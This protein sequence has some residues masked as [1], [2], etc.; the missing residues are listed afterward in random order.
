MNNTDF[1]CLAIIPARG[2]SRGLPG[3]NLQTVGG[4]TL[5]YRAVRAA[6]ESGCCHRV[7]CSTDDDAISAEAVRAGG[8]VPFRRPDE[9]A[10]DTATSMQVVRHAVDRIEGERGRPVD[11]VCLVE[12]T[13]PL[14]LPA[15][16]R[17]AVDLLVN[18]DPPADSAVSVCAVLDAHPAWL[19]K[20]VDGEMVPYFPDMPEPTRRQDLQRY[21][22][23]YRRNGA[24]YVTRRDVVVRDNSLYG[25][26]CLAC[27]MPPERS[28][29]IDSFMDLVCARAVWQEL[30]GGVD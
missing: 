8:D 13:T 17:R 16:I 27:Q 10:S 9:L 29:N 12:P 30:L 1:Y 24:V 20:V 28:I 2:G 6:I 21:P 7:I 4:R 14:R 11:L 18:A 22:A 3:K 25:R 5:V 19:R 26:R 15:D 23:P